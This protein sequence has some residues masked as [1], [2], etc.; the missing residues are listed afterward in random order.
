MIYSVEIKSEPMFLPYK[1]KSNEILH[2]VKGNLINRSFL[3]EYSELKEMVENNV[4]EQQIKADL[5]KGI[6]VQE[7]WFPVDKVPP[8]DVFIS[9]SHKDVEKQI[10]PLASWLYSNLGLRCFIDSLFWQYADRLQNM[11]DKCY[12]QRTNG[13]YDYNLR[14]YTTSHVHTM[15]SMA[16][17]K[18]MSKTECVLFVD[19]DNSIIYQKGQSQTPSPWIY[20]EIGFAQNLQM[21]IPDRYLQRL[22]PISES[23]GRIQMRT[24][25]EKHEM[26]IMYDVDLSHFYEISADTLFFAKRNGDF[27]YKALDYLHEKALKK[28]RRSINRKNIYG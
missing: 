18:M 24:F 23:G 1:I 19:S 3:K 12:A 14:N 17:M 10:K 25:S 27:G 11:M 26:N 8:F 2:L 20:A 4:D 16:L 5:I 28:Y 9:H 7:Q 21:I 13:N 15:L 22:V 6:T